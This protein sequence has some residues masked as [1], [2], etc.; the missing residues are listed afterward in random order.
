MR[1]G[2][3]EWPQ[4]D[5][6]RVGIYDLN[7]K[8]LGLIGL[9]NV[10]RRVAELG[11]AFG[12]RVI[13]NKRTRLP[14]GEE[15]AQ[16]VSY[17]TIGD[18]ARESDVVGIVASSTSDDPPIVNDRL[19]E[20]MKPG[21]VL[22]NVARGRLVDECAVLHALRHGNLGGYATDV[23]CDEPFMNHALLDRRDVIATPHIAGR[24]REAMAALSSSCRRN[25]EAILQGR[26]S[27][28]TGRVDKQ[29]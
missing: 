1:I 12:M 15:L 18:V 19:V 10:G 3:G 4:A 27:D 7:S 22:I 13:Y 8:T 24:S 26:Q 6:L 25:L 29:S 23:M 28:V 2:V 20:L 9:G 11:K 17:G 14:E 16:G 5:L 21:A